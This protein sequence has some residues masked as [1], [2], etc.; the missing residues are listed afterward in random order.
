VRA[1]RTGVRFFE[2]S[3]WTRGI[4]FGRTGLESDEMKFRKEIGSDN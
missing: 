2:V 4:D 1:A 3:E